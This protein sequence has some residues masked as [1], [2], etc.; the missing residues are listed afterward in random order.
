MRVPAP[1]DIYVLEMERVFETTWIYA[2]HE[3]EIPDPG[4]FTRT[5]I[6]R[7]D[8]VI[9]CG[10]DGSIIGLVNRCAP[11]GSMPSVDRFLPLPRDR[12]PPRCGD[13]SRGGSTRE[14][15]FRNMWMAWV[16]YMT[17]EA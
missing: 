14:R 11:R 1:D 16:D 10:D 12:R 13:W 7:K 4:D 9:V 3:N 17:D 8:V 5:R 15:V 6:G 2:G